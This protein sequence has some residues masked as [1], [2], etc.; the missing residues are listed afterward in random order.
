MTEYEPYGARHFLR[1]GE[2]EAASELRRR[3][4]PLREG[5][6]LEKGETADIDRFS[7]S[8]LL[9]YKTLVL[10]RSPLA[11]RPPLPFQLNEAGAYYEVWQSDGSPAPLEHLPL[12][13]GLDPSAVPSCS[14]IER[15]AQ[16]PGALHLAASVRPEPTLITLG[17]LSLPADWE[18]GGEGSYATPQSDGTAEGSFEV[19]KGGPYGVWLGGSLRGDA[20]IE[21]DGKEIGSAGTELDQAD[22]YR[23]LGSVKLQPGRHTIALT[24][25]AASPLAPGAG[26]EPFPIG[27]L[28][29][30]PATAADAKVEIVDTAAARSLCG[31]SLD[32]V[33][34]LPY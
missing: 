18:L 27:P 10:R 30:S 21:I 1:K 28:V 19:E 32:W 24:Y 12:G 5:G 16:T 8:G 31:R 4:V 13:E 26:G 11:S 29:V 9:E 15:L 23:Q 22:E 25:T 7:L 34:A 2:A 20:K 14:A 33:E 6:T 17:D 3:L